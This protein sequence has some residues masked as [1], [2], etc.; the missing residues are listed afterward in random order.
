M[1]WLC[2]GFAGMLLVDIFPTE[3]YETSDAKPD[4]TVYSPFCTFLTFNARSTDP[5]ITL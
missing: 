3:D 2:N 4:V 5:V 1:S